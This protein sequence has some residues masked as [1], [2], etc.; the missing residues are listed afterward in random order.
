MQITQMQAESHSLNYMT[1]NH[2]THIIS[3]DPHNA[4]NFLQIAFSEITVTFLI[5]PT[6][7]SMDLLQN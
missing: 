7:L 1:Y 2:L 3:Y 6:R 4:C 5:F